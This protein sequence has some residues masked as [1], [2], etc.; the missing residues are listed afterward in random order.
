VDKKQVL[1]SY[2][3][4]HM[5]RRRVVGFS[6]PTQ[7]AVIDQLLLNSDKCSSKNLLVANALS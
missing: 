7:K 5:L 3:K 2:E 4:F 6:L 1:L